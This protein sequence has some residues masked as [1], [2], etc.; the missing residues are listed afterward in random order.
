MG[1]RPFAIWLGACTSAVLL[2]ACKPS[3]DQVLAQYRAPVEAVFAR[4]KSLEAAVRDTP[5]VADDAI[6]PGIG[7]VVLKAGNGGEGNALFILAD[8]VPAPDHAS[9]DGIGGTYAYTTATCGEALNGGDIQPGT[10][11]FL[12]DCARAKY[13]FVL[14]T[15]RHDK[16]EANVAEH[17]FR[18]GAYEGDVLLFR[19]EDGALLGGFRTSGKSNDQ[20]MV[21]EDAQGQP[22]DA[23]DRLESDLSSEVYADIGAKLRA[24]IPGSIPPG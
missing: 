15:R 19:I 5:P 10:A 13:V 6:S 23:E 16:P 14:R 12:A 1:S 11:S 20:I 9:R 4:I 2:V 21:R 8:D 24:L 22:K 18:A 17:N 3:K 7:P